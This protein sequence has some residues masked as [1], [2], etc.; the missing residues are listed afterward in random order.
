MRRADAL[1]RLRPTNAVGRLPK[2]SRVCLLNPRDVFRALAGRPAIIPHV[3][4]HVP[5]VFP[6]VLRAARDQ[7]S[8]L[9]VAGAAARRAMGH[10]IQVP[11]PY[12]QFAAVAEAAADAATDRAL[13]L[14]GTLPV[15]ATDERSL[16]TAREI[17]FKFVDAGFTGLAVRP[18]DEPAEAIARTVVDIAG[19]MRERELTIEVGFLR[20]E[21]PERLQDLNRALKDRGTPL[22]VVTLTLDENTTPAM[23]EKLARAIQPAF[24]SG[25]GALDL[26]QAPAFAAAGLRRMDLTRMLFDVAARSIPDDVVSEVRAQP[27]L[28]PALAAHATRIEERVPED[29][30]ER[31]EA[32]AYAESLDLIRALGATGS[33][34][35][36]AQFLST[37]SGY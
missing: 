4:L 14:V 20:A 10:E 23:V 3:S 5:F 37:G 15:D 28:G 13:M 36:A 7:D 8:V 30:R 34:T 22:D 31:I 6:G 1:L 26:R 12:A 21:E 33:A 17:V 2:G 35:A 18:A 27:D 32:L 29:K 9:S 19:P 24:L 25:R 11:P 16:G